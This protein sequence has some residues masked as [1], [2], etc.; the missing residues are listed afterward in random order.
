MLIWHTNYKEHL[1]MALHTKNSAPFGTNIH[2]PQT[3]FDTHNQQLTPEE[4]EKSLTTFS[5]RSRM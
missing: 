3:L 5:C 2:G 1:E 4:T